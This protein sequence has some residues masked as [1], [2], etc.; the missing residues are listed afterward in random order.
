MVTR[1][2]QQQ[3][4][5][6]G[7]NGNRKQEWGDF[8]F[9]ANCLLLYNTVQCRY[10]TRKWKAD[11]NKIAISHFSG[12]T[13]SDL[14]ITPNCLEEPA[15]KI[16]VSYKQESLAKVITSDS[17]VLKPVETLVMHIAAVICGHSFSHSALFCPELYSLETAQD[18]IYMAIFQIRKDIFLT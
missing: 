16:H 10:D 8:S 2:K 11:N 12:H 15:A 3:W 13:C 6:G 7:R 14:L 1:N 9:L 17:W 5:G 18:T 4:E